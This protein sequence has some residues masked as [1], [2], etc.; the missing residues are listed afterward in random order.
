[1]AKAEWKKI[2]DRKWE[3]KDD[4]GVVMAT[5]FHKPM[6]DRFSLWV[7]AP[8]I[9]AKA[10]SAGVVTHQ[11]DTLEQAQDAFEHLCKELA[12]P[13]C[14]AILEYFGVETRRDSTV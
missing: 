13:W 4:N 9:F 14:K 12:L 7:S 3:L 1:M 2:Q 10:S 5:I 6:K 11:F 8:R